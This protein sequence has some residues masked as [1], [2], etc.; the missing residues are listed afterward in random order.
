MNVTEN[1]TL[2]KNETNDDLIHLL[3]ASDYL[4]SVA[5]ADTPNGLLEEELLRSVNRPGSAED[6]I[7]DFKQRV[8]NELVARINK[9]KAS[10]DGLSD[11]EFQARVREIVVSILSAPSTAIPPGWTPEK[12]LAELLHDFLGLGALE[13][14]LADDTITEIMVNRPDQIYIE[15]DGRLE[16]SKARFLNEAQVRAVIQRIVQPLGRHVD[17]NVPFV[18]ARL[19]DGSRVHAIIP[20]LALDGPKLTIRKFFKNRLTTEDLLRLGSLNRQMA[21]FLEILV[22]NRAN[23]V[24]S[25][26]TGTGKTTLLNVLS[27]FIPDNQRIITV[28]DAAE[29]KINK[30]HVVSLE[31]RNANTEGTGAV[32]IRELVRNTLRMRPDRIVV[33]EARGGEALDMLQAMNTGHDG[34]LTTIHANSSRDALSRLETLVLMSGVELPSRAI[35][36]QIASA[37]GFV[38]QLSRLPDGSRKV[39]DITEISGIG[40]NNIFLTQEIFAFKQQGFNAAGRVI[41]HFRPT[42]TVPRMVEQLRERGIRFPME[43]FAAPSV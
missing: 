10:F 22:R 41:G 29:L 33:G 3:D 14:F 8:Q 25:G 6:D 1:S 24:I 36:E 13:Q 5:K 34:S 26:G 32:S 28:E 7:F 17:E 16:L 37:I 40:E 39:T 19:P 18:D 12:L 27:D 9:H 23:I 2:V 35:R 4:P 20:P 15:R 30:Q 43:L 21:R 38:V 31:A 42:G 11:A